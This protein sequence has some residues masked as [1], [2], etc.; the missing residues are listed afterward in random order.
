M[1]FR[2]LVAGAVLLAA[3]GS[4]VATDLKGLKQAL[5]KEA[6]SAPVAGADTTASGLLGGLGSSLSLPAISEKTAGNAAGVLQYCVKRKYLSADAVDS[7]KGKLLAKVGLQS[8]TQQTQDSSYQSGL[9]GLLQGGDGKT[10]NL[11]AISGKVKDK[12][13]DYVLDNAT[14]LI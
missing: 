6:A 8:A 13:C 14:S 7:V 11:D 4:A 10:L 12:A 9:K 2:V 3:M 1:R 5:S